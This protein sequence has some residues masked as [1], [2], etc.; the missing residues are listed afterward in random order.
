M[1]I[2]GSTVNRYH[3]P[4]IP[5]PAFGKRLRRL[6]RE[7]FIEF[8]R[9]LWRARGYDV[10]RDGDQLSVA[11]ESSRTRLWI[12]HTTWRSIGEVEPPDDSVDIVVSNRMDGPEQLP[13]GEP[14]VITAGEL[15]DI[16]LYAIDRPTRDRLFERYLGRSPVVEPNRS[17]AVGPRGVVAVLAFVI[18]VLVLAGTAVS[19]GGPT[20]ITEMTTDSNAIGSTTPVTSPADARPD[21]SATTSTRTADD[22]SNRS[23][24]PGVTAS[25]I[26]NAEL[27]ADRH[28]ELLVGRSYEVVLSYREVEEDQVV[29]AVQEIVRVQEP[30]VYASTI[31]RLD[32]PMYD[33]SIIAA[34]AAYADGHRRVT[35][36]APN[37]SQPVARRAGGEGRFTDRVETYLGWYLTVENSSVVD[38]VV[39]AEHTYYWIS[40]GNDP[41][42]GLVDSSGRVLIDD[43]GLVRYLS[44]TYRPPDARTRITVGI[45]YTDVG[46][47]TVTPPEWYNET[48]TTATPVSA[49]D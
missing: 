5:R 46:N 41:W 40:L 12:H 10:E 35:E 17:R 8:V 25:G 13:D 49:I 21:P 23:Y 44:V 6:D 34:T 39:H 32:P 20:P 45:R 48:R 11:D 42:P 9:A 14:T 31:Q 27:I 7:S 36:A 19:I 26:T 29:G 16:A 47:T 28:A 3:V 43:R 22:S 33:P 24:P 38:R 2:K 15:R 37:R 18:A 1:N 30:T 4:P